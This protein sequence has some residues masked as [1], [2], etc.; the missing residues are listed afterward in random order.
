[1][2]GMLTYAMI[3]EINRKRSEDRQISYFWFTAVKMNDISSEYR[4]YYPLGK[5]RRYRNFATATMF[6]GMA[7]AAGSLILRF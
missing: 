3:G 2:S 4:D 5:L 7:V 6:V 1:M